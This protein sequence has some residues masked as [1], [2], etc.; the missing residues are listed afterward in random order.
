MKSTINLGERFT[1][2][3]VGITIV[4]LKVIWKFSWTIS[5]DEVR[6]NSSR[7]DSIVSGR[8]REIGI[9]PQKFLIPIFAPISSSFLANND[10]Y[11]Q[12]KGKNKSSKRE[13]IC[14]LK[15]KQNTF[16][17]IYRKRKLIPALVSVSLYSFTAGQKLQNK[18]M[19][20]QEYIIPTHI[21]TSY[22]GGEFFYLKKPSKKHGVRRGR[23]FIYF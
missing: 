12:F 18:T 2:E 7:K 20:W 21:D 9:S 3:I 5:P 17:C 15:K 16:F 11:Y 8:I 10:L 14:T 6:Q 22:S 23:S 1:F 19:S 4:Y 13:I